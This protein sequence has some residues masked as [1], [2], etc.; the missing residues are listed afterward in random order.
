MLPLSLCVSSDE[1]PNIFE[2]S[3]YN[4]DEVTIEDVIDVAVK[5]PTVMSGVPVKPVAVEPEI[6][7]AVNTP[8]PSRVVVLDAK[9]DEVVVNAPDISVAI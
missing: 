5:E 9:L 6:P 4:I 2:P 8:F 3:V 7:A 1:S